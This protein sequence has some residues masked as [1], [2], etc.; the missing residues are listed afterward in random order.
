MFGLIIAPVITKLYNCCLT[1][2]TFPDVLKLAE[3]IPLY[4]KGR[5][6]LCSNYRPIS[7][8]SPFSKFFEKCLYNGIC[9]FFDKHNHNQFGFRRENC[10]TANAVS[11]ICDDFY[12][13]RD[14]RNIT[15]GIFLDLEKA[16]DTVNYEILLSK[17]CEYGV[18]SLALDI[19]KSYLS[20]RKHFTVVN[21]CKSACHNLQCGVPQGSML[22]LLL[23]IIYIN[24]LPL[25]SKFGTRLFADDTSLT[26]SEKSMK[27]LEV[28][29]N[30]RDF[31]SCQ[32]D[33]L[34]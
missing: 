9:N 20:N 18:Q 30:Q 2:G 14:V 17:L 26:F 25:V 22:G 34:K 29:V 1:L 33:E 31:K 32:L 15:C 21:G 11:E 4:K 5:K 8:L 7:L 28:V 16:F 3:I 6:E 12:Q 10:S 13:N 27:K 24:D 23:F 19:L